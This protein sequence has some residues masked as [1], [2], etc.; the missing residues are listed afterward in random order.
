MVPVCQGSFQTFWGRGLEL[1][2]TCS[3][4]HACR[5]ATLFGGS[6]KFPDGVY[7]R[8]S[9]NIRLSGRVKTCPILASFPQ[10]HFSWLC[11]AL[12]PGSWPGRTLQN[13]LTLSFFKNC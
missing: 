4:T 2:P 5:D 12:E 13:R 10:L 7:S 6:R 9:S 3:L 8:S 1:G 11:S